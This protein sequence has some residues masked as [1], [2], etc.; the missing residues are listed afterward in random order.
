MT[1]MA[2]RPLQNRVDPF[3]ALVAE[4]TRYPRPHAMMGNRGGALHDATQTVVR[5][6]KSRAWL[7]CL[8]DVPHRARKRQR[9]DNRAFNGRKRVVMSPGRCV[10][11]AR[12]RGRFRPLCRSRAR[13][14]AR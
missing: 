10:A 5:P 11:R 14:R 7:T 13:E 9:D 2:P 12:A 8:L 1:H 3:G 6:F 4:P